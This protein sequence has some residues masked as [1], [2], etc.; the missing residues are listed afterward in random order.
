MLLDSKNAVICGA[1]GTVD[2]A[3]AGAFAREGVHVFLT[4]RDLAQVQRVAR[5]DQRSGRT[6]KERGEK[7]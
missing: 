5:E 2:S 1:A 3:V 4:G 7:R 6:G